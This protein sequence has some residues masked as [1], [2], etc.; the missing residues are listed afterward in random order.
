MKDCK[1]KG[2]CKGRKDCKGKG[3]KDCK[4]RSAKSNGTR[5]VTSGP[6]RAHGRDPGELDGATNTTPTD[7]KT[8]GRLSFNSGYAGTV[9][10]PFSK[11]VNTGRPGRK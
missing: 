10:G 3:K 9:R 6:A 11:P 4:G 5:R 8:L 1:G 7:E 2:N